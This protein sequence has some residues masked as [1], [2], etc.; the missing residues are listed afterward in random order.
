MYILNSCIM[1]GNEETDSGRVFI[2]KMLQLLLKTVLSTINHLQQSIHHEYSNF[3]YDRNK[4]TFMR[5][6]RLTVT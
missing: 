4:M 2:T 3:L 1:Y 5:L 6:L